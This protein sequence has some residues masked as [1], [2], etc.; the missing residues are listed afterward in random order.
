VE[1]AWPSDGS[2]QIS[3]SLTAGIIFQATCFRADSHFGNLN[4][5]SAHRDAPIRLRSVTSR[6]G[7]FDVTKMQK[8]RNADQREGFTCMRGSRH[9]EF[10]APKP[11]TE[12][13]RLISGGGEAMPK[14]PAE[15]TQQNAERA[16]QAAT[17]G[18]DWMRD[19]AEQSLNQS[20]AV[21][22]SL[23]TLARKAGDGLNQQ[24]SAVQR[25]SLAVTEE[26]FANMFGLGQKIARVKD[27]Q[28][29]V[30]AQSDFLS[31]QAEIF[32]AHSKELAQNVAKE[33]SELTGAAVRAAD[34][35]RK[36]AEAA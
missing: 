27:P 21:V 29:L 18:M 7:P 5:S 30:Q 36:R 14:G 17:V 34:A 11:E 24:A 4:V 31:R 33:T 23:L 3:H 26:T 13:W 25:C 35:S 28:Q 16:F 22:Q 2:E 20:Q 32:A 6:V 15:F 12:A 19:A 9:F 10:R 1:V 8:I